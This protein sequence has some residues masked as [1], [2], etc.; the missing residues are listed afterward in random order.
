MSS[1]KRPR[2]CT[3]NGT[4][5]E[6]W[7]LPIPFDLRLDVLSR[8]DVASLLRYAAA[9]RSTR[10]D[11]LSEDFRR[12]LALRAEA[13]R[14]FDPAL[15]LGF[16]YRLP[17][18]ASTAGDRVAQTRRQHLLRFDAILL[19]SFDPVA[20]RDGLVVLL[21]RPTDVEQRWA[22]ALSGADL[23]VCNS[24]TGQASRLPPADVR[25]A[26]PH[27]LL[28]VGGAGRSFQLLA[29]D[30]DLRMQTFSSEDGRWGAVVEPRHAAHLP[31]I[32]PRYASRATVVGSTVY[33]LCILKRDHV[34]GQPRPPNPP[35]IVS[36]DAGSSQASRIELPPGCLDR[37][38]YH[39]TVLDALML[40][41]SPD[42][43][44]SVL[45]AEICVISMWTLSEGDNSSLPAARWTRQ[46]VIWRHAIEHEPG[47]AYS[48]QFMG[49]GERSGTVV[50]QMYG[51]GLV[52][53]N[54]GSRE[55]AVVRR[56]ESF[57]RCFGYYN[58]GRYRLC[59]HE[60]HL[61]ALLQAMKPF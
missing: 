35:C 12:S 58:P 10:S 33:W 46:V 42:R 48:V 51:I 8:L 14:G 26:Y 43:R 25:E 20:S 49:L 16:S 34:D 1:K 22:D 13:S 32:P 23:R 60:I 50:L 17:V 30:S 57:K 59:L 54:L 36:L 61:T 24:L 41:P 15:L 31:Y 44:L 52:Q 19:D 21:R 37:L 39:Q 5:T 29:A 2:I 6:P 18:R 27:A 7:P 47:P 3:Y 40:A 28:A 9:S 11:I 38:R 4:A 55:A 53:L 45:A 56:D